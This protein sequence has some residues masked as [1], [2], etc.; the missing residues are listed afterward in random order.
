MA[1]FLIEVCIGILRQVAASLLHHMDVSIDIIGI[2]YLVLSAIDLVAT[3]LILIG[4][5]LA[6]G[7]VQQQLARVRQ[8]EPA[9]LPRIPPPQASEPFQERKEGSPDIQR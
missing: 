5:A 4:F 7:K 9:P 3:A 8:E 6:L 2:V 1:G